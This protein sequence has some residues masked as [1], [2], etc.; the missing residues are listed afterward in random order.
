MGDNG[1]VEGVDD[2]EDGQGV[3]PVVWDQ[4]DDFSQELGL[5]LVQLP[6]RLL[7]GNGH[8]VPIG[9]LDVVTL[10]DSGLQIQ[11][12]SESA[13]SCSQD[14]GLRGSCVSQDGRL[15]YA[16][17]EAAPRQSDVNLWEL[18]LDVSARQVLGQPRR[19][20]NWAGS[21]LYA[22]SVSR[23]GRRLVFLRGP[24]RP[25]CMRASLRKMEHLS[26]TSIV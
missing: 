11:F 13:V 15:I 2:S 1:L 10:E 4:S 14:P 24:F 22:L 17:A 9:P 23:D 25:M 26:K 20:T 18:Q 8:K 12:V 16:L 6:R 21:N 5:L 19:L 7:C 3:H